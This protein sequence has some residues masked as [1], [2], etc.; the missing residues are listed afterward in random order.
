MKE[1]DLTFRPLVTEPLENTIQFFLTTA[2]ETK[3]V[4]RLDAEGFVYLG[5]R[6][7]DA[8]EA[9]NAWM[10]VMGLMKLNAQASQ[11]IS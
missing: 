1:V 10:E 3:E 2:P 9:Y 6:I 8:G 7:Q 11:E 4:L 5:K